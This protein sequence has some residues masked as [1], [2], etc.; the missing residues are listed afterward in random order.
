MSQPL[1]K[2]ELDSYSQGD[3]WTQ[4]NLAF[5]SAIWFPSKFPA[6]FFLSISTFL[7]LLLDTKFSMSF[8]TSYGVMVLKFPSLIQS[9]LI[10]PIYTSD[11]NVQ[12]W[13]LTEIMVWTVSLVCSES[14]P[15][16]SNALVGS[17]ET[18]IFNI[19]FLSSLDLASSKSCSGWHSWCHSR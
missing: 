9:H 2:T 1:K 8:L 13:N 7:V 10:S 11:E 4:S 17:W 6:D 12:Q 15:K 19:L 16:T 14:Y 5:T 3:W 18:W